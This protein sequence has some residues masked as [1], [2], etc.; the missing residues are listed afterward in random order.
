MKG[1][2]PPARGDVLANELK[3]NDPRFLRDRTHQYLAYLDRH[4]SLRRAADTGLLPAL[5]V[6]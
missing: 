3:K 4:G 2:L 6:C 5:R 1:S